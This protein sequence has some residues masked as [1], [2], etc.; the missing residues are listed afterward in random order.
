MHTFYPKGLLEN[1]QRGNPTQNG[2][3]QRKRIFFRLYYS[4]INTD[5]RIID[6]ETEEK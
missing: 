6:C 3:S 1:I 5:F 4:R 2:L